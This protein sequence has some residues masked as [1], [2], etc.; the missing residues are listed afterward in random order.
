M[1]AWCSMQEIVSQQE[2]LSP[3]WKLLGRYKDLIVGFDG[4]I[5]VEMTSRGSWR[6][7]EDIEV[8]FGFLLSGITQGGIG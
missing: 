3:P 1:F 4:E 7:E 6:L 2:R 8:R 5:K